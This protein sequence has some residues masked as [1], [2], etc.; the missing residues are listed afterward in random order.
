VQVRWCAAATRGSPVPTSVPHGTM[1]T[2]TTPGGRRRAAPARRELPKVR[3]AA[4]LAVALLTGAAWIY[5]VRAA[6]D[7]GGV[8][9]DGD[10]I[11]WLFVALATLGAI[12]CLLLAIVLVT[13]VLVM[14]GLVRDQP[15][16]PP[17]KRTAARR[18]AN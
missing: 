7:F 15:K 6:I 17:A 16:P 8:A 4:H 11:A 5:L 13:R 12:G 18:R 14:L 2:M 9:R 3:L 1:R 10:G